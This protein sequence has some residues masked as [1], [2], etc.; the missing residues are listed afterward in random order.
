M[1]EREGFEPP[2]PLQVCR[3]SSAVHST[4]LPPLQSRGR[5][6]ARNLAT[7]PCLRKCGRLPIFGLR[8]SSR[9]ARHFFAER[10]EPTGPSHIFAIVRGVL[11]RVGIGVDMAVRGAFAVRCDAVVQSLVKD[12]DGR[13]ASAL[14]NIK[15]PDF[16][17]R[18]YGNESGLSPAVQLPGTCGECLRPA[19]NK[20][21]LG[22]KRLA[23][24]RLLV[25][26]GDR[27]AYRPRSFLI[28]LI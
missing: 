27:V 3:I 2:I 20:T 1:A 21:G 4:T 11:L 24:H 14:T 18:V 10:R 8:P 15:S 23:R 9:V 28:G 5:A 25:E 26:I 6:R 19:R 7:N 22:G 17:Y 12:F 13:F 16:P